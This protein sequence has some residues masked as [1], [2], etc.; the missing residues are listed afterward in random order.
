ME[1]KID[2]ILT[3]L[4][5]NV[6]WKLGRRTSKWESTKMDDIA[7]MAEMCADYVKLESKVLVLCSAVQFKTWVKGISST[8]ENVSIKD[9]EESHHGR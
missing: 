8:P 6:R 9:A 7:E 2:F 3:V 1:M 5:Y 4:S